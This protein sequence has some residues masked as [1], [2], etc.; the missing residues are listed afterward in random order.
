MGI[1]VMMSPYE[2]RGKRAVVAE[3]GHRHI[4]SE[5][6][7]KGSHHSSQKKLGSEC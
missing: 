2:D 3:A 5:T 6:G 7:A 1:V 4:T